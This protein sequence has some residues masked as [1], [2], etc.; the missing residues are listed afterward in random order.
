MREVTAEDII[1]L[2]EVYD[3]QLRDHLIEFRQ[4]NFTRKGV[5]LTVWYPKMT[6][7]TALRHPRLGRTQLTRKKVDMALLEE[8]M[9]NP[10]V[11]TSKG[12][13]NKP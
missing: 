11:H 4:I 1:F 5:L 6:V 3:W 7:Q 8:I 9:I 2:A 12:Y 10:R 13:R